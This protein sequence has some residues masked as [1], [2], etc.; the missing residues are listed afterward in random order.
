MVARTENK[1]DRR[2]VDINITGHG[3]RVLR[4]ASQV[5]ESEIANSM[6]S[7]SKDEAFELN[8]ILDKLRD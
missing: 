1:S 5:M 6:K 8:E 2:K 3:L 7:I 4:E